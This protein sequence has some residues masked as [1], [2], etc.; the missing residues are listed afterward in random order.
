MLPPFWP[1]PPK[2]QDRTAAAYKFT[3]VT[4]DK[5]EVVLVITAQPERRIRRWAEAS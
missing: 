4:L 1:V 2:M 3:N 5:V